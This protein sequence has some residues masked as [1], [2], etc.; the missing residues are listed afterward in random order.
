VTV[1]N[2]TVYNSGVNWNFLEDN[3]PFDHVLR[4][5]IS[6]AG[7]DPDSFSSS[8][9]DAFNTWNGIP[10]N[11]ADFLSLDDTIARGP[12]QPDGSLP[13]SDFLRL[14]SGSNLIDAGTDVGLPYS[15]VAPDLGAYEVVAP[16][17]L[18]GDYNNNDVIDAADYTAWR[19]AMTG[20]GAL[21]NDPT[22]GTVDE[23]DFTYW[24]AHFGEVLGSGAGSQSAAHVPEPSSFW[25]MLVA[26]GLLARRRPTA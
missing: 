23:S 3:P 9:D 21:T 26:A 25:L 24:R 6:Y 5:N 20:G 7:A 19:D 4:N 2:S 22:P 10:V 16:S 13:S 11:A 18:M 15:G 14:V 8:V 17:G 12:R 1:N